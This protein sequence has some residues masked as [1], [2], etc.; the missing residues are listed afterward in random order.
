M[1]LHHE[2][3]SNVTQYDETRA[4]DGTELPNWKEVN[5][6]LALRSDEQIQQQQA[7]I[8]RLLRANGIAYSTLS[9]ADESSRPWN[10]DLAPFIVEPKDWTWL[11]S[12]LDQRAR[13]KEA[14]F[15]DIYSEQELLKSGLI[16]PAMVFAHRGYQ[17]DAVNP[18]A[19][20]TLPLFCSDLARSTDGKWYVNDDISQYPEGSGY[21][22]ENRLAITQTSPKLFR[23][24][25][26][27]RIASYFKN[28]QRHISD[29]SSVDDR[30]VLLAPG[31]NHPHY[32]EIAYLAKYLGYTLVHMQD[33]T[34]RENKVFL[35]TVSGMRHV[36]VIF[37]FVDDA[38][39]KSH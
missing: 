9:D 13:L 4:L 27:L 7:N 32:F 33:L 15:S 17:R 16:P 21:A 22:L 1:S 34:V 39:I 3:T 35:K 18:E 26:V 11:K 30:C 29:A 6:D 2:K 20:H 23:S 38:N 19:N 28:I 12:A 10:L 14:I 8:A 5:A 36:S 25:K 37:R 24:A 31:P